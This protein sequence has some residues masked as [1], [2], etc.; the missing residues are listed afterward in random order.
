MT[1]KMKY[2]III[3]LLPGLYSCNYKIKDN[4][5]GTQYSYHDE[6]TL[7]TLLF[8]K[9]NV[10]IYRSNMYYSVGGYQL[11]KNKIILNSNIS[12]DTLLLT[13]IKSVETGG[14]S[15]SIITSYSMPFKGIRTDTLVL[16][17][18]INKIKYINY[19]GYK[20]NPINR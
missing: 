13:K 9:P 2:Y 10:F 17:R 19:N 5:S 16:K 20:F 11:V 7:D 6:Y 18:G 1:S 3:F 12:L 4:L 8:I 14:D 15:N